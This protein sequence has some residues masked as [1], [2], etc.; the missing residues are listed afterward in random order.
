MPR[1]GALVRALAP[2]MPHVS[3]DEL[4]SAGYEGLIE[5]AMRYDPSIG[6][7]FASYAHFRVRGAMIDA[8]RRAEPALRRRTRALAAL[9]ATQALL[10]HQDRAMPGGDVVDPRSLRERVAAAAELVAQA[11]AAVLLSRLGSTDPDELAAP[12]TDVEDRILRDEERA[13]LA[14]L[15]AESDTDER[16]MIEALYFEGRS[17]QDYARS[18]GVAKSTVSRQHAR[19]LER[20]S[21]A[22]RRA[23]P[24]GP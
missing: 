2:M 24:R 18:L 7:P 6:V 3:E 17:M 16:R 9:Q 14:R 20:L 12:D 11:T 22:M 8:A 10:Q 1:V 15:L 21:L 5:A 19:L 13:A 4:Q 23:L